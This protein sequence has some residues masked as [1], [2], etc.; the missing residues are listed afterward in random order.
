MID[1]IDLH[2]AIVIGVAGGI[3]VKAALHIGHSQRQSVGDA[4]LLTTGLHGYLEVIVQEVAVCHYVIP[5]EDLL[6]GGD[7]TGLMGRLRRAGAFL[8][9][10]LESGGR[11]V[12][13]PHP[14]AVTGGEDSSAYQG[15]KDDR[16]IIGAAFAL[17]RPPGCF[18]GG[19]GAHPLIGD[20][21]EKLLRQLSD[22]VLLQGVRVLSLHGEGGGNEESGAGPVGVV[23][24]VVASLADYQSIEAIPQ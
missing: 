14:H 12:S 4:V 6:R 22:G 19:H 9:R 1:L 8:D 7:L 21:A 20:T 11:F 2:E 23:A 5:P 15:Q 18:M 16:A 24:V 17:S 10:L 13:S 3:R